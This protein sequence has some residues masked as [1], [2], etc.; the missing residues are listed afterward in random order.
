M[1]VSIHGCVHSP[2]IA[3]TVSLREL[4][5]YT[6]T[7]EPIYTVPNAVQLLCVAQPG[8][9]LLGYTQPPRR[10]SQGTRS[11]ESHREHIA[12]LWTAPVPR[13][14]SLG[15]RCWQAKILLI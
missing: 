3:L 2:K 1:P 15:P 13:P 6:A 7:C 5:T 14:H 10:S 4:S 11:R 9:F 8:Y 12:T